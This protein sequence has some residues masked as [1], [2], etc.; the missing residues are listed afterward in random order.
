MVD[1]DLNLNIEKNENKN[2]KNENENEKNEISGGEFQFLPS[3]L[4][5]FSFISKQNSNEN[6]GGDNQIDENNMTDDNIPEITGGF[7]I[8]DN[9]KII[10]LYP[11]IQHGGKIEGL[12]NLKHLYLPPGL[13]VYSYHYKI[14]EPNESIVSETIDDNKFDKLFNNLIHKT[15]KPVNNTTK[16][17]KPKQTNNKTKSNKK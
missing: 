13:F 12:C 2:E 17:N 8:V 6:Y 14:Q 16:V 4:D 10:G 1:L 3:F 5:K 11:D 9:G 7:P 15:N